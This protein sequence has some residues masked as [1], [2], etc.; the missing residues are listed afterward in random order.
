M[1]SRT[2]EKP[3]LGALSTSQ[4][5]NLA[6]AW[7]SFA[8]RQENVNPESPNPAATL[9]LQRSARYSISPTRHSWCFLEDQDQ[10]HMGLQ[11]VSSLTPLAGADIASHA[12]ETASD[13]MEILSEVHDDV[14]KI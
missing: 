6:G 14:W 5:S 13:F 4:L 12:Q 9:P 1:P 7:E 11:I 10:D 3:R 2:M 8:D